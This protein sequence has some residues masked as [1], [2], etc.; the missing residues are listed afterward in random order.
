MVITESISGENSF[1]SLHNV[2]DLDMYDIRKV[3]ATSNRLT[4]L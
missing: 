4:Y 1:S 2:L 3:M